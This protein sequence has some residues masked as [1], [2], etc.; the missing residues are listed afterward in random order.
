MNPA[1]IIEELESLAK[2]RFDPIE[3]PYA[4]A[5]ATDNASATIS[6]LRTG[7]YNKSD[8]DGGVLLGGKFH[9]AFSGEDDLDAKLRRIRDSKR[10]A[11]YKPVILIVTDGEAVSAENYRTGETLRCAYRE[12]GEQFSFFLPAAGKDSYKAAEENPIDVKATGKLAK[13]YDSLLRCNP[14][15]K[16]D[17]SRHDMNLFMTRLIFC[18]FSED[19]GIFPRRQFSSKIYDLGGNHGEHVRTALIEAFTA[20]NRPKGNRH[21]LPQWAQDIEYVNGGL[22]S[23]ELV[24]PEFD[25]VSFGYLRDACELKWK[26]INPD[27]FGSMIQSISDPKQRSE[28]GMHYT[29]VPNI[30]KV[31]GPLLLDELDSALE[32]AWD[33]EAALR[34]LRVRLARIRVFDPACG[35]G[36]F[37]VVAY[38]ELRER[39]LKILERLQVLEGRL[40]MELF[41]YIP[42]TNFFGI[43][44]SDFA[45]ETA[46]L[47]LFIA[48]YQANARFVDVFGSM[49]PLLPLRDGG[50]IK[51]GNALR[52]DWEN[53]CPFPEDGE[54]VYIVGNPPYIGKAKQEKDKKADMDYVFKGHVKTYRAFD[55]VAGW[56]YKAAKYMM[57]RNVQV[58]LVAT[59]SLCQGAAASSFWPHILVDGIEIGFAHKTFKWANNASANA[60]VGCVIVGVRNASKARKR[61]IDGEV[62]AEAKNINSYLIDDDTVYVKGERKSLF[63]LPRMDFGC[64]P[65]DNGQLLLSSEEKAE[66][67]EKDSAAEK[68]IRRIMGSREAIHDI[69]RYCVW[70]SDEE[71]DEALGVEP[72]KERIEATRKARLGMKDAAGIALA[73]RAHQ[74]REHVEARSHSIIVP[75]ASSENRP[76]LPVLREGKEVVASNLC[77]VIYDGP[78]WCV[79]LIASRL[80]LA[81]IATVCGRLET[82]YRYSNTLGWHT[83]PVPNLTQAQKE[84]LSKSASRILKARYRHY[85]DS[86][87]DLYDAGSMPEDLYE[88]HRLN[89]ELVE[90]IYIGRSFKNDSER[91]SRLF[92]LYVARVRKGHN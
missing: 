54:E 37:L 53:V 13:L 87:A 80:H 33:K 43:E 91:I 17:K 56:Y 10:T 78:D 14:E 90:N 66:L 61:I 11:K 55:Y 3:F 20:M 45:A 68:F 28:L 6:K 47:A 60:A 73:S 83:F 32:K 25:R 46:K 27:I 40:S 34:T 64:M 22:F 31:L 44:L 63:G 21:S 26:E 36:N 35:S 69:E 89:D 1:E 49:P 85:P 51:R 24:V 38:R 18:M 2:K 82:R 9:Y 23:G 7:T 48:E 70:I 59:N 42:L 50:H 41:S 86:I 39:E 19:V 84:E 16:S 52:E 71:L 5:A 72:I 81:W 74:F 92:R 75:G 76:Y 29:S 62:E 12:L 67:I 4:F 88:A 79:A 30:M 77:Q 57:G 65:Y 15:W 58:A 8:I